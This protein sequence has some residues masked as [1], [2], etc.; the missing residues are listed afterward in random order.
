MHACRSMY[1]NITFMKTC[2][3]IFNQLIKL[4]WFCGGMYKNSKRKLSSNKIK[5][6]K[7]II[8]QTISRKRFQKRE[9]FI[10]SRTTD[11]AELRLFG[12]KKK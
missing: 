10:F 4:L 12:A 7:K 8:V 11:I 6:S 9:I 3:L 5:F 2:K 1:M